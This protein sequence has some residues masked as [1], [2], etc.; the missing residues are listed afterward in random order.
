MTVTTM[1]ELAGRHVL[2]ALIGFFGVMLLAN[3]IF[4]YLAVTTF[5]GLDNPN[6]YQEGVSYNDRIEAADRQAALGWS[7]KL[8]LTKAG[9]MELS[10]SDKAGD[11][12]SGLKI[13][14][15]IA[16][17]A[18]DRFTQELTFKEVGLGLY[19]A[20]VSNIDVGNWIITLSAT[21]SASEAD[22]LYRLMERRWLKPN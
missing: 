18:T 1:K 12:I 16:R 2:Y 14:G 17:P 20:P 9:R 11:A 19:A 21:K 3:G 5:T 7:H 10:I 4:L 13:S 15:T 6:A 22:V 8:T